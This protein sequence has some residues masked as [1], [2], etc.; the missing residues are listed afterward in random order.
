VVVEDV[1]EEPGLVVVGDGV[2][3]VGGTDSWKAL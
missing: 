1:V 3:V 2:L